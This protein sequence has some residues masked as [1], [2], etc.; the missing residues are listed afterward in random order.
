[1]NQALNSTGLFPH[2]LSE[3]RW[4]IWVRLLRQAKTDDAVDPYHAMLDA[5]LS[6][7]PD[8]QPTIGRAENTAH[9]PSIMPP[10][11][12]DSGAFSSF[13]SSSMGAALL[14]RQN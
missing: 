1:M 11:R 7:R 2:G 6:T 14:E 13:P 5:A 8:W 3:Q 4:R 10:K 12:R 9:D